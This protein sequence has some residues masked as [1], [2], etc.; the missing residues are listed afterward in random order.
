MNGPMHVDC[1]K[2][3]D[4]VVVSKTAWGI[5]QDVDVCGCFEEP[6]LCRPRWMRWINWLPAGQE[7]GKDD[8]Y[9]P[10]QMSMVHR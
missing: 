2:Y 3:A 1:N 8:S 6:T 4:T 5:M 10:C 7:E 9:L